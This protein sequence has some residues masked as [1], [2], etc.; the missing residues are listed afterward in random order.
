MTPELHSFLGLTAGGFHRV[1]Y[2]EWLPEGGGRGNGRTVVCVHGLTRNGR[3]FDALAA[4]LA[5]AGYRVICPDVVGRGDSDRLADARGYGYP[6]Y[7]ADMAVLI[8]R[9]DVK[10][11][12]WVGTSMGALIGMMLGAQPKTP[13]RTLVLNDAGAVIP[14]AALER[15]AAYV[16]A[17]PVFED[18]AAAEQFARTT[19]AGFGQLSDAQWRKLTEVTVLETGNGTYGLNYDPRIADAFKQAELN[20]VVLWPV[21]D[22]VSCPSLI[23]RGAESDLLLD[24]TAQEMTG[25]GPKAE[26]ATIADCAH[27]PAL[28]DADQIGIIRDWLDAKAP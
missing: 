18:F 12:D 4:D 19:Y 3:D 14:K 22:A 8:A 17:E 13:L 1:V 16:G 23:L 21:W 24:E 6:Q 5:G 25:R 28:M 15:I 7:L 11:V 26:L 2:R 10:Q 20:D 9:L 27:A